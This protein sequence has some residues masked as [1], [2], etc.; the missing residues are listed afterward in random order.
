VAGLG[1]LDA[2]RGVYWEGVEFR[3]ASQFLQTPHAPVEE[4][5]RM[6]SEWARRQ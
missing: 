3:A 2:A 6:Y 1:S 5:M 4:Y